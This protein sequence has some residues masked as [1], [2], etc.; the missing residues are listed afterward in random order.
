M[1]DQIIQ[2]PMFAELVAAAEKIARDRGDR[3]VGTEH[4][5][6]AIF[7]D[8]DAVATRELRDR[9]GVDPAELVRRLTQFMDAPLPGPGEY[10][11]RRLDGTT[12]IHPVSKS[13]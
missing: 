3:Y 7:S 9:M 4:L 6:V 11:V 5:A 13:A 1:A 8:P 12:S 2:T 10:R